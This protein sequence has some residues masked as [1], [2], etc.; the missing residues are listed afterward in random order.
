MAVNCRESNAVGTLV[1]LAVIK[2]SHFRK[3][4]G[5]R[6]R[7]DLVLDLCQS[8]PNR[9]FVAVSVNMSLL[10]LANTTGDVTLLFLVNEKF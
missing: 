2:H 7:I 10:T 4:D 9:I 8:M 6:Y 1:S 5:N 3:F